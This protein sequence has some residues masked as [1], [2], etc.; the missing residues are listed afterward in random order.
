MSVV[1]G[2]AFS[3]PFPVTHFYE[4]QM[5]RSPFVPYFHTDEIKTETEK[6]E[7][8]REGGRE[9]ENKVVKERLKQIGRDQIVE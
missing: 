7:R 2:L 4:V 1:L 9:R 5:K 3:F 6:G 8:K